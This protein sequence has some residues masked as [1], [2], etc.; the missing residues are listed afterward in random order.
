MKSQQIEACNTDISHLNMRIQV[1]SGSLQEKEAAAMQLQ[2]TLEKRQQVA[3]TQLLELIRLRVKIADLDCR[4]HKA[5]EQKQQAELE[6]DTT[7][8]EMKVKESLQAQI[9]AHLSKL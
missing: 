2:S 8:Q 4:L 6:R 1:L 7:V 3:S 9:H 5:E